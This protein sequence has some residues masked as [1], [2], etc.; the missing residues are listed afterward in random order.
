MLA[1]VVKY[2]QLTP[3]LDPH[4]KRLTERLAGLPLALA[5]AG[6]YL[7]RSFFAFE[8]Y[9]QEYE[10]R[11]DINP[12]RPLRLQEYQGRTL[13]TTWGLSHKRLESDETEAAK[14]L[15]LLAYFENQSIWYELLR[16]GLTDDLPE[17]MP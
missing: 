12:Q 2:Y 3:I 16:G 17:W 15:K 6:A 10:K 8:R 5:T 1:T 7:H 9:L 14:I 11:W 13:Y 4:A